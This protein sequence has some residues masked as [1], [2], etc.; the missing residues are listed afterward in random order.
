M[1]VASGRDSFLKFWLA[2]EGGRGSLA[3]KRLLYLHP[4]LLFMYLISFSNSPPCHQKV[5]IRET[6]LSRLSEGAL[7]LGTALIFSRIKPQ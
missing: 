3:K 6:F 5:A 7:T 1:H 4:G 2:E